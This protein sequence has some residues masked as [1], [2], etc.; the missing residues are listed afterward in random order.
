MLSAPMSMPCASISRMR[1]SPTSPIPGPRWS[2]TLRPRSAYASG[3]T[4]CAW[5]SMVFA[6]RPP[7]ATSRRRPLGTDASRRG[8]DL[9]PLFP[10]AAPRAWDRTCARA[11]A[12]TSHDVKAMAAAWVVIWSPSVELLSSRSD[13]AGAG[14]DGRPAGER[15]HQLACEPAQRWAPSGAVEQHVLGACLA[16]R[17]HHAGHLVRDAV[18]GGGADLLV[19]QMR[20]VRARSVRTQRQAIDASAAGDAVFPGAREIFS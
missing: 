7:T 19:G 6:R 1:R 17:L 4:Q 3:I 5:T 2:S 14:R 13:S 10:R 18:E 15:G 9:V 11:A 16:Q 8:P 12:T 20:P